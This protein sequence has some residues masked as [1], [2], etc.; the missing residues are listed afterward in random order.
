MK[1][2][3]VSVLSASAAAAAMLLAQPVFADY[4]SDFESY[5]YTGNTDGTGGASMQIISCTDS[6]ITV[7]FGRIKNDVESYKYT[8]SEGT[9]NGQE[10]KIPFHAVQANGGEFDGV[11]TLTFTGGM[12]KISNVSSLGTEIYSGTLPQSDKGMEYFNSQPQLPDTPSTPAP[13][14]SDVKLTINDEFIEFNADAKPII[15]ND[16]TYVPLRSVFSRMGINV[17]WDEYQKTAQLHEQLITCAKN[18][19][20]IQFARTK[21]YSG[22]NV[23]ALN[24]WIDSDTSQAY[25]E[26]INISDLQPTIIG[27]RSYVPLRVITEA[28][29]DTVDWDEPTR[30]VVI[31]CSTDNLYWFSKDD[32]SKI[33]DFTIADAQKLITDDYS[34]VYSSSD[35]PYFK[36]GRKFYKFNAVD[37]WGNVE[38][39]VIYGGEINAKA[40]NT[41]SGENMPEPE[42]T[43]APEIPE[44]TETPEQAEETEKPEEATEIPE[45]TEL[46]TE[47]SE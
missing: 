21:N 2:K 6:A 15:I 29:G 37:Q 33:E 47:L 28:L 43:A 40:A 35:T 19:T 4:Y 42:A 30:T 44:T 5:Y 36:Y 25:S 9:V 32:I 31:K 34:A 45:T 41:N 8:F 17:F 12:V 22:E 7:R 16:R 23:W 11:M 1:K 3:V 26:S 20:I 18:D 13:T 10:A 27:D 39:D 24:K 46:P 38:L 14:N